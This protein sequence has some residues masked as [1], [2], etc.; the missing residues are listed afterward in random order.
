MAVATALVDAIRKRGVGEPDKFDDEKGQG[1]TLHMLPTWTVQAV[2][3]ETTCYNCAGNNCKYYN[4]RKL[5]FC[6][7]S[8]FAR[9]KG[10][11]D[12]IDVTQ[13]MPRLWVTFF[14]CFVYH[15]RPKVVT[16][17][18]AAAAPAERGLFTANEVNLF[19]TSDVHQLRP[20]DIP[21]AD[22]DFSN[23]VDQGVF[24]ALAPRRGPT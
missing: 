8:C 5:G 18:K 15:K 14:E 21:F 20:G 11:Q 3:A 4:R 16:L 1:K 6:C 24:A 12:M 9:Q 19:S 2:Q 10:K 17:A 13:P 22:A 23:Q 7:G